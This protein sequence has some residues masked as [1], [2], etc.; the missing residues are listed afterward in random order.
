MTATISFCA[1]GIYRA[2]ND[3]DDDDDD[4]NGF[5]L[6]ELRLAP[7]TMT[8]TISFYVNGICLG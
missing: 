7:T 1:N 6:F 4:D 3:T 8:A 5:T 2:D